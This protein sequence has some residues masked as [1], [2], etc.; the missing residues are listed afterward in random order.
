LVLE[1]RQHI[2]QE[3]WRPN[4]VIVG[5]NNDVGGSVLDTM[6][7]LQT[8]V[9]EWDGENSYPFGVDLVG[10]VLER[11]EHFLLGDNENF[12]GLANKPAIGGLLELLSSVNG[13]YDDSDIFRCDVSR[14]FG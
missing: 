10:E 9:G 4:G 1:T 11:A 5:K 2:W 8:L 12:L 3:R 6:A 14:I 13:R 7:H